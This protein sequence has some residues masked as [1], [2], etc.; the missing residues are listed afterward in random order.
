LQ[1][2]TATPLAENWTPSV[3]SIDKAKARGL[4]ETD[5]RREVEKFR[6]YAEA[7]DWLNVQ[8]DRTFDNWCIQCGRAS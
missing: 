2:E 4:T 3:A 8:W 1:K 6:N 5:I 7:K